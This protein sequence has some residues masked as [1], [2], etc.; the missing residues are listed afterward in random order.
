MQEV[1]QVQRTVRLTIQQLKAVRKYVEAHEGCSLDAEQLN[2][3]VDEGLVEYHLK[4]TGPSMSEHVLDA[5]LFAVRNED[6]VNALRAIMKP[7]TRL[8]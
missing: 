8:E 4:W 3:F 2:V 5:A 7:P 1:I 6:Q